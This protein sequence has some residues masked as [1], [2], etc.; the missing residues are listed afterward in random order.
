MPTAARLTASICFGALGLAFAFLAL[1]YFEEAQGPSYWFP[2]NGAVGIV[3][4]WMIAGS[5][6]GKGTGAAIGNGITAVMALLFWV[7][8]LM[9]FADMIDKSMRNA[10]DGPVEAIVGVF[11]I[12]GVYAV[13][14]VIVELGVLML[15]GS[16][17]AGLIVEFASSRWS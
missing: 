14:F 15:I 11:E 16:I 9:S 13:Q 7:F 17:I 5:R 2:L 3:V 4:G 6:V 8:F 12:M 1:A 10:Y